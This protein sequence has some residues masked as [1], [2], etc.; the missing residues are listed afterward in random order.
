MDHPRISTGISFESYPSTKKFSLYDGD[1]NGEVEA[2]VLKD[3][4]GGVNE[5]VATF[6]VDI[7]RISKFIYSW[8]AW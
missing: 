8:R 4:L 3:L 1:P 6:K 2:E 5:G 7:L